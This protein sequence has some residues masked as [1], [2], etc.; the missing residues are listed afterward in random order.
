MI[1]ETTLSERPTKCFQ[2]FVSKVSYPMQ[3]SKPGF[4]PTTAK[5]KLLTTL[6]PIFK[7]GNGI[8]LQVIWKIKP[9]KKL[10]IISF[11]FFTEEKKLLNRVDDIAEN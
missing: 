1:C 10:F 3:F 4:F 5:K 11:Y 7:L 8:V 9:I 2:H 6:W